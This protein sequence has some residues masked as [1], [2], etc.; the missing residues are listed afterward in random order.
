[1]TDNV[2]DNMDLKKMKRADLLEIMA[3]PEQG[4]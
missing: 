1:M 3:Q 2:I 4:K